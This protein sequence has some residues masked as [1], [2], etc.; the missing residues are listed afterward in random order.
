MNSFPGSEIGI[1]GDPRRP[2]KPTLSM[3]S[4]KLF[5][6]ISKTWFFIATFHFFSLL[7]A[8]IKMIGSK[9]SVKKYSVKQR[10][11]L[12]IRLPENGYD[13]QDKLFQKTQQYNIVRHIAIIIASATAGYTDRKLKFRILCGPT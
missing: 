6:K 9:A 4:S 10:I 5:D 2:V 1:M 8:G 12:N 11:S 13:I 3:V 7:F